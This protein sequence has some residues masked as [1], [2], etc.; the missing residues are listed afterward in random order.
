MRLTSPAFAMA[1]SLAFC[2]SV[3]VANATPI[4]VQ[5]VTASSTFY[6]YDVNHLIDGSGL[7]G[8]LHDNDFE[9]MWLT[10]GTTTGSVTFDLGGLYALTQALVWNYN[11]NNNTPCCTLSRGVMNMAVLGSLDNTSFFSMGSFLLTEGTGGLIPA[12]VLSL[13][14]SIARYVRFDLQSDF[15]DPSYIGLSEVQFEVM[16]EPATLLLLGTGLAV[17]AARRRFARAFVPR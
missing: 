16:P 11:W 3:G 2:W 9:H 14:S 15:G 4:V 8:G 13:N 1:L 5:S 12:D 7:S 17:V 10:N 6:T